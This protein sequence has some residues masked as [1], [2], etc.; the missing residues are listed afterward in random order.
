MTSPD[1]I[2]G[3]V[4]LHP[5]D[6]ILVCVRDL[7]AGEVVRIDGRAVAVTEDIGLGHKIARQPL[8]AGDKVLRYGAAIGSMTRDV[9]TGSHVHSHNLAS[10]YIPAHGRGGAQ[11]GTA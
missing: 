11:R 9:A 2:P 3:A 7:R 5:D 8:R 10:D 1:T 6:N 4:L